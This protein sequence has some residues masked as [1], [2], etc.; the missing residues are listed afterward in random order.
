M[1]LIT[2]AEEMFSDKAEVFSGFVPR[3]GR[4]DIE[5]Y[6]EMQKTLNISHKLSAQKSGS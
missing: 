4:K 6:G 2:D 5:L 3:L 1:A